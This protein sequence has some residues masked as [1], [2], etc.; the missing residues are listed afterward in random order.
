MK[1][2]IQALSYDPFPS[3]RKTRLA[4]LTHPSRS[5]ESTRAR[6]RRA[7]MGSAWSVGGGSHLSPLLS[8]PTRSRDANRCVAAGISARRTGPFTSGG[9][10]R[11]VVGIAEANMV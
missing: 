8:L 10:L 11:G 1:M 3:D 9:A 6:G 2:K 7:V 4:T 5:Q